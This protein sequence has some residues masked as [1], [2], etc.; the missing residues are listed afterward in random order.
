MSGALLEA[1][2][3][4]GNDPGLAAALTTAGLPTDDLSD[5]GRRF[6]AFREA[7]GA[8]TAIAHAGWER[9]SDESA[10]LRS[11]VVIPSARGRGLGGAILGR[12][13]DAVRL[14]GFRRA[15][16]I[17]TDRAPW[18]ARSGFVVVP[19][20]VAPPEV[21]ACRQYAGLCPASAVVMRH[22]LD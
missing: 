1:V 22:D 11:L 15:W 21:R 7:G 9:L 12:L 6:L 13:M 20:D 17:T 10:L 19:R 18:F 2:A 4:A 5:S 14:D 8:G 16:L 3:V